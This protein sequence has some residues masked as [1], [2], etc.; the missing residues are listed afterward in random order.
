MIVN[1][2]QLSQGKYY[3]RHHEHLIGRSCRFLV[4]TAESSEVI[5]PCK[6]TLDYPSFL[7][8][9]E[10]SAIVGMCNLNINTEIMLDILNEFTTVSPVGINSPYPG[11]GSDEQDTVPLSVSE[12]RH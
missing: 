8:W 6:S 3:S 1:R 7:G 5:K 9:H 2:S 10:L 11:V 12:R 4:I